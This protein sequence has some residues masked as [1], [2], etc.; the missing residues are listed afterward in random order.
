MTKEQLF[1]YFPTIIT[2]LFILILIVI[3]ENNCFIKFIKKYIIWILIV[4]ALFNGIYYTFLFPYWS[5]VDEGSHFAYIQFLDREKRLP[6][7]SDYSTP[8]VLA[9]GDHIYPNPPV[10]PPEQAGLAGSLYEAFQPPL[11]YVMSL[12]FY[13]LGGPN[14]VHKIY[15]L[16]LWGLLQLLALMFIA[17]KTLENLKSLFPKKSYLFSA[18]G[19]II[20]GLTPTAVLRATTIGN[21]TL[22]IIFCSLVFWWM[23]TFVAKKKKPKVIDA[24]LFGVFTGLAILSRITVLFLPPLVL[25]FLFFFIK[26]WKLFFINAIVYTVTFILITYP[27]LVFNKNYYGT[28]T[29]NEQAKQLQMGVVNPNNVTFG[30][31]YVKKEFSNFLIKIWGPEEMNWLAFKGRNPYFR[32]LAGYLNYTWFLGGLI[33]FL[34]GIY[35]FLK[36]KQYL[37]IL[38][39]I[40]SSAGIIGATLQQVAGSIIGNWPVMQGRYLHPVIVLIALFFAVIMYM[41]YTLRLKYIGWVLASALISVP[42]I[43]NVEYIYQLIH[44]FEK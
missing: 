4:L 15:I 44:I 2:F 26:N 5:P 32:E 24:V 38:L 19:A 16:R 3:N 12:P 22:P 18:A 11:Y 23:S 36:K 35:R 9:L 28:Y 37:Y 6:L 14:F 8:E 17:Y 10:V 39:F 13:W 42:L 30:I 20:V 41:I 34:L 25:L 1:L 7:L 21:S 31:R 43:L 33:L 27:W 29:S 40:I